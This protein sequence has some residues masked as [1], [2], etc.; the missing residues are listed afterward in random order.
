M[1]PQ[2][3]KLW[4]RLRELRALGLHFRRQSPIVS[5]IVDF[6]CRRARLII[7]V[8]GGQHNRDD[9]FARDRIRDELLAKAG[10]RV[11]RFW[12]HEIDQQLDGVVETIVRVAHPTR[13]L[14]RFRGRAATLP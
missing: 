10:Y 4:V 1:T 12:N 3:V 9:E 5:F 2:E 11:L 6:E 14:P 13:P 7:E 8:D